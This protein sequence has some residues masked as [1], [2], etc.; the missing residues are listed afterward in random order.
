MTRINI[1]LP[2]E[3][4]KTLKIEAINSNKPLKDYIVELLRRKK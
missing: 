1:E 3:L 4:H 2:P